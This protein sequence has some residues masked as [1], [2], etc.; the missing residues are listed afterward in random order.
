MPAEEVAER[1]RPLL[2]ALFEAFA[3]APDGKPAIPRGRRDEVV[4]LLTRLMTD[5]DLC[6]AYVSTLR[7]E[8]RRRGV[9][10][11]LLTLDSPDIPDKQIIAEGFDG[12]P[13]DILADIA[14]SP[15]ALEALTV[16]LYH[17]PQDTPPGPWF[18]ARETFSKT[19]V[20][21][22]ASTTP[23]VSPVV[24][25]SSTGRRR[26]H[27]EWLVAGLAVAASFLVGVFFGPRLFDR[28]KQ[29]EFAFANLVAR[30][31]A[32]RGIADVQLLVTNDGDGRAFVTVVGLALGNKR[33][34]VFNR[35]GEN[36]LT[37]SPHDT[38]TV[39][40]L[41][42]EFE[43]VTSVIIVLT[44]VPAGEVVRTGLPTVATPQQAEQLAEQLRATL[45]TNN[46][47]AETRVV[48]IPS[49]KQ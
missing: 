14:L 5:A 19:V 25:S 42:P 28:D 46:V 2:D 23:R 47:R 41:P 13:D 15:G 1:Y 39:K 16:A 49:T 18:F 44:A 22:N 20:S 29:Q 30:G 37:V 48:L 31:D 36:F 38:T 17:D 6:D 27:L 32:A 34:V 33:A 4:A 40:N 11:R 24:P 9:E 7:T 26:G 3:A 35:T 12:L 10:T 43:G 45:A 8:R 21:P